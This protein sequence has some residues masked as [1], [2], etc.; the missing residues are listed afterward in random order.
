MTGAFVCWFFFHFYSLFFLQVCRVS[1]HTPAFPE[2]VRAVE[3]GAAILGVTPSL[4]TRDKKPAEARRGSP[5]GACCLF[6]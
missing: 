3:E 2:G 6:Q 1:R 4:Q 5:P